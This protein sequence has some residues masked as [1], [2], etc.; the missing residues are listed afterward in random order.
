MKLICLAAFTALSLF[1]EAA[2]VQVV[3]SDSVVVLASSWAGAFGAPVEV[4]GGGSGI[5]VA[6]LLNGSADIATVARPLEV[7]E[8]EQ[9]TK[10]FGAAPFVTKVAYDSLAVFV[11]KDNPVSK[12]SFVGLRE[13]Y[14]NGGKFDDWK[15]LGGPDSVQ[16][17]LTARGMNSGAHYFFREA[18]GGKR[19]EFK[20]GIPTFS[21]SDDILRIIAETPAAIGY[22][23]PAHRRDGVKALAV[24]AGVGGE[25][26]MPTAQAIRDGTY[27][28]SRP[29][30][31]VSS[32]KASAETK[33]FIDFVTGN[34]G[35]T[36][37]EKEGATPLGDSLEQKPN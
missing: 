15:Q 30:Y 21:G 13:I 2:P 24:S 11:H 16:I 34:V 17:V 7:G 3:G 27:P 6:A 37:A 18:V 23:A 10:R 1:A 32:P 14:F 35:Q 29:L 33:R 5:G 4:S 22:A 19:A 9:L 8:N 31:F 20:A 36:I 28:L 25:P 12:I 26:V